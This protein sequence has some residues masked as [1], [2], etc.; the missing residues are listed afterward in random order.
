MPHMT[1][2]RHTRHTLGGGLRAIFTNSRLW[3]HKAAVG[4]LRGCRDRKRTF[5]AQATDVRDADK[6]A[7]RG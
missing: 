7:A 1:E 3:S 5:A 4:S 2:K 6:A